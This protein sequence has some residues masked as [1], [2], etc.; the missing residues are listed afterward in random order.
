M[1]KRGMQI[2]RRTRLYYHS[3]SQSKED[4][5]ACARGSNTRLLEQMDIQGLQFAMQL[6]ASMTFIGNL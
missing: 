3:I 4:W 5:D 6:S 1:P 2:T